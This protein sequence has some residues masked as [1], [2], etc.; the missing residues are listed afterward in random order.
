MPAFVYIGN[1]ADWRSKGRDLPPALNISSGPFSPA[2]Q[3]EGMD[4]LSL[5]MTVVTI[6]GIAG[7]IGKILIQLSQQLRTNVEAISLI[8]EIADT[9]L[10]LRKIR[11]ILD[12]D[13][14]E[15][16]TTPSTL[17]SSLD[18]AKQSL[19]EL[20]CLIMKNVIKGWSED[21]QPQLS[22][23]RVWKE[24]SRMKRIRESLRNVRCNLSLELAAL[25]L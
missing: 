17:V 11:S 4:P 8:N 23:W 21:G 13:P 20:D 3:L 12:L 7:K 24:A 18:T 1:P 19:L 15:P 25:T 22:R 6:I 14:K 16:V 5:S 2:L 10:I 9:E